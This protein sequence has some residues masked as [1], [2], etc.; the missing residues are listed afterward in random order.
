M[1]KLRGDVWFVYFGFPGLSET[2]TAS[3]KW[4]LPTASDVNITVLHFPLAESVF[5]R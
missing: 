4:Y 3:G 1:I 5:R 2:K